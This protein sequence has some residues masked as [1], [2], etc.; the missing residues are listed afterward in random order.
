MNILSTAVDDYPVDLF[1]YCL[2]PNHWHLVLASQTDDALSDLIHWL[3]T[4]HAARWRTHYRST[5]HG[6]V[7]QSRFKAFLVQADEHFLMLCRYVERNAVRAGLAAR[8]ERWPW[9]SAWRLIH[10]NEDS[11][12]SLTSWPVPQPVDWLEFVNEP[13]TLAELEDLRNSAR[14]GA[15]YGSTEWRS[16]VADRFGLAST[17]RPR[18]RPRKKGSDP[19]PGRG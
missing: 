17:L 2:M 19:F 7:Y 10:G 15:P 8:A 5:G 13:I 16:E 6:H 11:G 3:T 9:S 18:G 1:S 4:T 14:R 12:P